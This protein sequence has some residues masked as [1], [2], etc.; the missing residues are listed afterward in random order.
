M[1]KPSEDTVKTEKVKDQVDLEDQRVLS[2]S[3]PSQRPVKSSTNQSFEVAEM[4]DVE[5]DES[6]PDRCATHLLHFTLLIPLFLRLI[7]H[8]GA[9]KNVENC[10]LYL[11]DHHFSVKLH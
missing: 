3:F 1:K 2:S 10:S 5:R 8:H 11:L 7:S 6:D 9:L 4:K